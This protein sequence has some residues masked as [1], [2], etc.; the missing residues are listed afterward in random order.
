MKE[1]PLTVEGLLATLRS[2]NGMVI[3]VIPAMGYDVKYTA[4]LPYPREISALMFNEVEGA[5]SLVSDSK[6]KNGMT[7]QTYRIAQEIAW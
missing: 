1:A 7:T 3:V 2:T 6:G 4:F 5:L